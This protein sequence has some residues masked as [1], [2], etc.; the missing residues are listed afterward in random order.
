MSY[1]LGM[2]A[3]C[4]LGGLAAQTWE[5]FRHL[6]PAATVVMDLG[7][8]GRGPGDP[9]RYV[10]LADEWGGEV[11][12][13]EGAQIPEHAARWLAERCDTIFTAETTYGA[14]VPDVAAA[15]DAQ[16]VVQANP[17]LYREADYPGA[18]IVLPTPWEADRVPAAERVLEV[19]LALDVLTYR[20]RTNVEVLYH[21]AAPAM[22][23][24][25]GT[26][27]L[28]GALPLMRRPARLLVRGDARRLTRRN[29]HRVTML[30]PYLGLYHDAYPPEADVLVIPRRYAG[31]FMGAQEAAALGMPVVALDL[32]PQRAWPHVVTVPTSSRQSIQMRGGAFDV[33][34]CT[35]DALATVLDELLADPDRVA[36]LSAA[37]RV[38]AE[39]RSWEAMHAT[40]VEALAPR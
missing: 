5:A 33:H 39:A 32:E 20:H 22:A 15:H 25:N 10:H 16:V 19:P 36:E 13:V 23:D 14:Y 1:R 27:L 17:E 31:N 40:Y 7:P 4:D 26:Y 38:W 6:H 34:A 24:R 35:P 3:R 11:T 21:P 12:M 28:A 18:R 30:G 8:A 2:L 9:A 37:G 29:D